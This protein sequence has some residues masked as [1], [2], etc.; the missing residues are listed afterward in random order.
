MGEGREKRW[1]M[2]KKGIGKGEENRK[3]IFT[4]ASLFKD[5]F[6]SSSSVQLLPSQQ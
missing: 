4:E 6:L 1:E 5:E 2:E 3:A